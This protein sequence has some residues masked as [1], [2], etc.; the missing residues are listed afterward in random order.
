MTCD[1]ACASAI[2]PAIACA[3]SSRIE[4]SIRLATC[5]SSNDGRTRPTMS[6]ARSVKSSAADDAPALNA[7]F[8]GAIGLAS[9]FGATGLSLHAARN[10]AVAAMVR[11][12]FITRVRVKGWRPSGDTFLPSAAGLSQRDPV[13]CGPASRP[14]CLCR[15]GVSKTALT[16]AGWCNR[17]AK[18]H[19]RIR[20]IATSAYDHDG[21]H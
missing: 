21:K 9:T 8:L 16:E 12:C 13:L 15:D 11:G 17:V 20:P 3:L 4:V 2:S 14:G 18:G 5:S 7:A 19:D 6:L 1:A 10:S